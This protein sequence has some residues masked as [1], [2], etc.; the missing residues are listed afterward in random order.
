M[1]DGAARAVG[2]DLSTGMLAEAR[3]AAKAAGLEDRTDYRL[4]DFVQLAAEAPDADITILD[5]VVCCYPDWEN[6]L[7][8]SLQ[9]TRRVY[10]LTY[11]RDRVITRT[12]GRILHWGM[13]L[14]HCCYQPYIHDPEKIQQRILEHG[15]EQSYQ[16]LTNSWF[17]QVYIRTSCS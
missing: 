8:R 4:G 15:F 17:T 14:I 13:E 7:D 11:P 9:K 12:G 10:A 3:K 2:I 5:K 1:R 6:L 16:A